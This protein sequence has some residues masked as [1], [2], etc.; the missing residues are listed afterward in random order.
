[1]LELERLDGGKVFID[2]ESIEA[3]EQ[4]EDCTML[5]LQSG[6]FVAVLESATEIYLERKHMLEQLNE[7]VSPFDFG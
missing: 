1:M 6:H 2:P 5:T 4:H 7:S 3:I